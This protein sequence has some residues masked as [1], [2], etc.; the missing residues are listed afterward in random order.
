MSD[1]FF[2][3]D[4]EITV[5]LKWADKANK[6]AY[7]K[8]PNDNNPDLKTTL[9]YMPGVTHYVMDVRDANKI[10]EVS[11]NG[12]KTY[13]YHFADV[14]QR[15]RFDTGKT[16]DGNSIL[17][18][19]DILKVYNGA[20]EKTYHIMT[21]EPSNYFQA[22]FLTIP[23]PSSGMKPDVSFAVK[24]LPNNNCYQLILKITGLCLDVDVR[25]VGYVEITAG[26][27]TSTMKQTFRCPV[28]S[29]YI[30][31]PG[32]DSVTVFNCLC[33]GRTNSLLS[34]TPVHIDWKGAITIEKYIQRMSRVLGLNVYNKLLPEYNKLS[35]VENR[36]LH[37]PNGAALVTEMRN[38]IEQ[39]IRFHENYNNQVADTSVHSSMLDPVHI[40]IQVYDGNLIVFATNRPNEKGPGQDSYETIELNAVK[41][42]S[43]NGV[44]LSVKALWNPHI[45]PGDVFFM[46]PNIINGA[47]LPNILNEE[48]YKGEG[49]E[50]NLYRVLT[51]GI[52]FATTQDLN[53][54]DIMAI[55]L[56]YSA[57]PM[58]NITS[59]L[60]SI[61]SLSDMAGLVD[62]K[63][64][65]QNDKHIAI[66]DGVVDNTDEKNTYDDNI[67]SML[68]Q[69][70]KL[71][72][73]L[74]WT[75]EFHTIEA[76]ETLS[77]I[78][79]YYYGDLGYL[80]S[81]INL[82]Y[83]GRK[84]LANALWPIIS[85]FTY[86]EYTQA[87]SNINNKFLQKES[88]INPNTIYP[89]KQLAIVRID[90]KDQ[91]KA[92]KDMFQFAIDAYG[93]FP[94]Y[95]AWIQ[96]WQLAIKLITENKL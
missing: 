81:S 59:D 23:C 22:N 80:S 44:A 24:T 90:S 40:S 31:S 26:Y 79:Q 13:T 86:W 8:L 78:A 39:C 71:K 3:Y 2:L 54:M 55:P 38:R 67:N 64:D 96:N 36:M 32:P 85:I 62:S 29:S 16:P 27:R 25:Q 70:G 45:I 51:L 41:G 60:G 73:K 6:I 68:G 77:G 89:G 58:S 7:T 83:K 74:S 94:E 17:Q 35:L 15:E 33:T 61:L 43:F 50:Q 28:F 95:K 91:F 63:Y 19:N 48:A 5:T 92:F 14:A 72:K 65:E 46:E 52:Q 18:D 9:Y 37:F 75:E 88:L 69:G 4:K 57:G 53:E 82:L 93:D 49:R 10:K 56:K 66:G 12:G 47:N 34:G 84:V 11:A 21:Q 1:P 20:I 87:A 30:E 76:G 42:A